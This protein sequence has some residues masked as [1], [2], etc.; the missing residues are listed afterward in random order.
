MNFSFYIKGTLFDYLPSEIQEQM[1]QQ[2]KEYQNKLSSPS[3]TSSTCS[4]KTCDKRKRIL[5][6]VILPAHTI[7]SPTSF[8][9]YEKHSIRVC[10]V[11]GKL[12]VHACDLL[13]WSNF[14]SKANVSR[15]LGKF[16]SPQQKA[17]LAIPG[18]HNTKIGQVSIVLNINGIK[19]LLKL[20]RWENNTEYI[21]YA[22][23]ISQV[24]LSYMIEQEQKY[25]LS[26]S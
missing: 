22:T 26:S 1:N 24:L 2:I 10:V 21:K 15:L 8:L 9:F 18:N 4:Y 3:I 20:K 19:Q 17:L 14:V 5:K 23:W 16:K 25:F 12:W 11:Q 13:T 6:S 7:N